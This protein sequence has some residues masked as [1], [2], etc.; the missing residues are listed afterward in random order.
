MDGLTKKRKLSSTLWIVGDPKKETRINVNDKSL[1]NTLERFK[2]NFNLRFL[3]QME[4][5]HFIVDKK[6]KRYI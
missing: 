4:K 1:K 2:K 6:T 5:V 3:S